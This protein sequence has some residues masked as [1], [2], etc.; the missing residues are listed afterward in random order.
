MHPRSTACS[1]CLPAAA[2]AIPLLWAPLP[3]L[4]ADFSDF[5]EERRTSLWLT[6]HLLQVPL[7]TLLALSM[8]QLSASLIGAP[9]VILR[10]AVVAWG[11]FFAAFDAA[12][13][14]ATE[15]SWRVVR[16]RR[17]STSTNTG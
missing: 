6:I 10:I 8:L 4:H 2:A 17:R 12:G 11:V 9:A 14:I 7:T 15:C 5:A 1:R 16:S 13:G 3:L